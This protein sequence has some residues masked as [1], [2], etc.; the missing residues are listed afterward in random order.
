VDGRRTLLA[1]R[2]F[3]WYVLWYVLLLFSGPMVVL[4]LLFGGFFVVCFVLF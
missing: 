4:F 1:L 2:G 3:L